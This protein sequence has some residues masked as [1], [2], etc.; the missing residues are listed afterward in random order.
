MFQVCDMITAK[1]SAPAYKKLAAFNSIILEKS[2]QTCLDYSY[3]NMIAELQNVTWGSEGGLSLF[4][5]PLTFIS[6]QLAI[7]YCKLL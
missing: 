2:N 5:K 1:G 6:R 7:L 3:D 4:I